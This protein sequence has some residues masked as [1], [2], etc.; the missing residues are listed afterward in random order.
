[1]KSYDFNIKRLLTIVI[2]SIILFISSFENVVLAEQNNNIGSKSYIKNEVINDDITFK[3]VFTSH[4]IYF[5]IDK[6][7]SIEN[8]DIEINLSVNQLVDVT[9]DSYIT[10]NIN[11][12][13]FYSSKLVYN[14]KQE[15]QNIKL[16]C[17]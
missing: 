3:G 1:M 8:V 5:N 9:K 15:V 7:W 16:R 6:W 17:Q 12:V 4:S 2:L 10:F 13:P 14:P 11:G